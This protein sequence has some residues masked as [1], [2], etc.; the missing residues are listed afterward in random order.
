M[1]R[2]RVPGGPTSQ[3]YGVRHQEL[4]ARL[5]RRFVPG[6]PCPQV[7]ADGSVCGEP[8]FLSQNL[9]LGHAP[10]RRRYLGLVHALCNARAAAEVTNRARAGRV[11]SRAA[12]AELPEGWT[13]R[14][15]DI[16]AS[17]EWPATVCAFGGA[18]QPHP[19][20]RC[21]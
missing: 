13:V 20:G 9:Q 19:P 17:A 21:W 18:G 10:D 12:R 16:C 1:G 14:Q 7:F 4:R 8:M 6:T 11:P 15:R 5:V 3:G 2:K